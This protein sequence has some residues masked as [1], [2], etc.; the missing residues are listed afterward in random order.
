MDLFGL[1]LHWVLLF[2]DDSQRRGN[3]E[4]TVAGFDDGYISFQELKYIHLLHC[5]FFVDF[6]LA[7]DGL[8]WPILII[9]LYCFVSSSYE[10]HCQVRMA[11]RAVTT[12]SITLPAS[13]L[14]ISSLTA[15]HL[16]TT[17]RYRLPT[18]LPRPGTRA[19]RRTLS[20][21]RPVE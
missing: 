9:Y 18:L 20:R 13:A 2:L 15:K 1:A 19:A 3:E 16:S 4:E 6:C 12:S 21:H 10:V 5:S 17:S 11:S 7:T 14:V 8:S